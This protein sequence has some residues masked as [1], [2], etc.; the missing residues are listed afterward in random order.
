MLRLITKPTV[1]TLPS[2]TDTLVYDVG[3]NGAYGGLTTGP[4]LT[5]SVTT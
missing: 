1:V 4:L 5:S 3:P 2:V